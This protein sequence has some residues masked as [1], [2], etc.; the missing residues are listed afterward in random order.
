MQE[1][2]VSRAVCGEIDGVACEPVTRVDLF[3][4][5]GVD[6]LG[7]ASQRVGVQEGPGGR[8]AGGAHSGRTF[9][10]GWEQ[11]LLCLGVVAEGDE[12]VT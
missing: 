6:P 4:S 5:L 7:L 3:V 1:D 11:V 12:R 8:R 2:R 10:R 9:W